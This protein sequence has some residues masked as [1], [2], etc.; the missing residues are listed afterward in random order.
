MAL[1]L[2]TGGNRGIGLVLTDDLRSAGILVSSACPGWVCSDMGGAGAPRS[3][4]EGAA[5]VLRAT[6]L[7]PD[8]PTGGF[9]RDGQ[10]VPW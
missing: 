6:R 2:V 9:L 10:P 4:K 1:A 3:V 5:S 8:G 7:G